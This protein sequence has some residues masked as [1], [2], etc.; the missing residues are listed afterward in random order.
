M[1][2]EALT[3]LLLREDGKLRF[4]LG[5]SG[6]GPHQLETEIARGS[7]LFTEAGAAATLDGDPGQLWDNTVRQMGF[8]PA[9][10]LTS[11]GVQ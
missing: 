6:W 5:Y 4:C 7:W 1:T 3:G 10:L 9:M 11:R 2:V 8:D